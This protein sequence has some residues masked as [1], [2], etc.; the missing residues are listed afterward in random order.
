VKNMLVLGLGSNLNNS[1]N[2]LRRAVQLL[3][4]TNTIQVIKIS[5]IYSSSALLPAD[6]PSCWNKPFLNIALACRSHLPPL[7]IL[8][9]VKEIEK[10]LGRDAERRKWAP[11]PIDI[12]ILAWGDLTLEEDE[13][14][15]PHPELAR[16]PFA[17]WP[18]LDLLPEWWHTNC[19]LAN[20][21]LWGSRFSGQA[22]FNTRQIPHRITG[23]RL[24]GIVNL[25]PDSFSDGGQFV[26]FSDALTH[27]EKLVLAGAEVLDIGAESTRPGAR[28]VSPHEEWQR[29]APMLTALKKQQEQWPVRPSLSVDTRHYEVASRA[30]ALG[31]DWLNDVSGFADCNM[32]KLAAESNVNCVIVHNLGVPADKN[33]VLSSF[34]DIRQQILVWAQK[35]FEQLVMQKINPEKFIFDIGI[36]FGKTAEQSAFLL[37]HINYFRKLACPLLVGHSRKSFLNTITDKPYHERDLETSILSAQLASQGVD[38][39]RIHHVEM[40][41][42]AIRLLEHWNA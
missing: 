26:N 34:P 22:P 17:L 10:K 29:L 31:I 41:A 8:A 2:N 18:L 7:E 35:R 37:K 15:I 13:L 36:G 23:T 30:L 3:Q 4:N 12:D 38:F 25:T 11:R 6:A 33:V 42:R 32:G 14:Q 40:N 27:A 21:P 9:M 39:L 28:A 19:E 1:L 24:V 20:L 5:P 16:R